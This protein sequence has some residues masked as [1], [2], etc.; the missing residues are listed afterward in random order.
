MNIVQRTKYLPISASYELT[1]REE[2][3]IEKLGSLSD[4]MRAFEQEIEAGKHDD[5]REVREFRKR[6]K[7]TDWKKANPEA[8][9]AHNR[10]YY[11]KKKEAK[12]LAQKQ[13]EKAPPELEA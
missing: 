2:K 11:L 7:R 8:R 12:K 9:K 3:L 6:N 10:R 4:G 5:I 13:P 1:K